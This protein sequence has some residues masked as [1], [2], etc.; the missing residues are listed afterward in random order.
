VTTD[1]NKVCLVTDA[2]LSRQR[3]FEIQHSSSPN[4]ISENKE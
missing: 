3:F 4:F 2:H 1:Q